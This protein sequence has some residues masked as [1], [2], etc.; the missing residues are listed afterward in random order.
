MYS[1]VA[2]YF[3]SN[4]GIF[5]PPRAV[6]KHLPGMFYIKTS[7]G[8]IAAI[9]HHN[10]KARYTILYSHGNAAD[11]STTQYMF[12]ALYQHG[13]SVIGYD[14]NGYGLSHGKPSE[15]N[16]YIDIAAVYNYL[17][18]VQHIPADHI[19]LMAHSLG[20]GPTVELGTKVK[21]AGMVLESAFL[22]IDRT[23]TIDAL[24]LLLFD[25]FNN[26]ARIAHIHMPL[27]MMHGTADQIIPFDNGQQL[28]KQA[29]APKYFYMVKGAGH[30]NFITVALT[31]YWSHL[32]WFVHSGVKGG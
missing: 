14:Y 28:F 26:A 29:L 20:T 7:R 27:L 3:T 22:S 18:S 6:Y 25:K 31:A 32:N 11:L 8:P 13:Y 2:L 5:L 30:N 4:A 19:I 24:P 1:F 21:A 15:K 10:S 16:T 23:V 12:Q 17:T 9:Y